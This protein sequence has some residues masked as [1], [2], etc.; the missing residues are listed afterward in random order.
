MLRVI[1]VGLGKQATKDH[2]PAILRRVDVEIVAVVDR[3]IRKA[4]EVGNSLGTRYFTDV[5]DGVDITHPDFA[6]VCVPHSSYFEILQVLSTNQIP[7][8]K[9]K[10]LALSV[11]EA[12]MITDLYRLNNTYLQVCVQ[13]RFSKLYSTTKHLMSKV[14]SIYSVYIE[15]AMNLSAQDMASG[16][17]ADKSISGGGATIDMGYHVV[18]LITYLFGVPHR[19]YAQL[20]YNSVGP[21]YTIDDTMKAL[22]TFGEQINANIVIT[23]VFNQKTE[24]VRIFGNEGSISLDGRRVVLF[25]NDNNEIES[26][27]ADSKEDEIDRQLAFFIRNHGRQGKMN[28]LLKDQMNNTIIIDAIYESHEKKTVIVPR[29][30]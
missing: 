7:T 12:N 29:G 24:K 3:D 16:W 19:L 15:Y 8:L 9:E 5:K 6:I 10:P 27:D 28:R 14:G 2:I 4:K 20:N 23:K 26:Y 22:M 18:D 1:I 25:D 30:W 17:R 21:G 11:D 13:R